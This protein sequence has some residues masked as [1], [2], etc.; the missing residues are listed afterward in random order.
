MLTS[1]KLVNQI[2]INENGIILYRETTRVFENGNKISETF[3]RS[4]LIP[5][6]SLNDVPAKVAAVANVAW[7]PDVIAAYEASQNAQV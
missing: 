4:S 7:T 5:G 2:T 1:E 3:H 6:Q